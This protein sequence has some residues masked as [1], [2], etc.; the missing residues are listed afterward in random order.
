MEG[1][2]SLRQKRHNTLLEALEVNR[3]NVRVVAVEAQKN[4]E[5][6]VLA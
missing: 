5:K 3:G 6:A 2:A 4:V 1:E